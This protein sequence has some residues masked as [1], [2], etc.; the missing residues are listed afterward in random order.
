[1]REQL[2]NRFEPSHRQPFVRFLLTWWRFRWRPDLLHI[3]GYTSDLLFI[4]EWAYAKKIPV[5]YEE[6]QT[7][8][9]QFDWWQDF[10]KSINKASTI[11]A[12][13][14]KS[15]RA[16]REVCGV[17]Q[18][19]EV[20]YYLVP[21]PIESGW[22]ADDQSGKTDGL[23]RI[24]TPARLYITKGLTYLLEAI[25]QVKAVHP[26]VQFRVYGDGPLHEELSAYAEQLGLDGKQIFVGAYTSREELSQIMAQTDIFVMSSIL[27]GLPIAL[28]E[29]MSYG[30]PAV[31]TT[32]GGIPEAIE[33]GVNGL[34]CNP[35]DPECLAQKICT[36]IENP[37]LRLRLGHAARKA[38]EQ[39]PY[40]PIAV[41]NQY[42]S[43]YQKILAS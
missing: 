11:V 42:I 21:D 25:V 1:V 22:V 36:L 39:G 5:I 18:P 26:T 6:H 10:K 8:D 14:E 4:I 12:V 7:P 43:I 30:R 9:A 31:V 19:I 34:L 38:Y 20:V 40:N 27:E 23:I 33:D 13:S 2:I 32:V 16:L 41:C 15:A 37:A 35:R 28:L 29:A 24:T 3:H 17:T